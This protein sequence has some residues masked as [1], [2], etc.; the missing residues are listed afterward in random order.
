MK[1]L[2]MCC[3]ALSTMAVQSAMAQVTA[4]D[5]QQWESECARGDA[6]SCGAA[7]ESYHL[8][9]ITGVRQDKFKAVELYTKACDGGEAVGCSNLG[10]MFEK[11]EGV[12]QDKFKAVALYTK[13]CD[14]GRAS[15]C[16]NLGV[17]YSNGEGVR[18]DKKRALAL[19][20]KACDMKEERGCKNYAKLKGQGH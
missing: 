7:G 17:M 11:G 19:F 4:K 12:K 6:L 3:I 2:L 1:R 10:V 14:G 20:G 18:L 8:S 5:V 16:S 13:A 9:N 15:G